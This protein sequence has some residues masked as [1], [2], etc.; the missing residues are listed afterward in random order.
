MKTESITT[1]QKSGFM[2]IMLISKLKYLGIIYVL[3]FY[4]SAY[5]QITVACAAN[6]QYAMEQIKTSYAKNGEDIKV[7]YGA[8][9]KFVSQIKNGAPFDVFV[10][11]DMSY[12]ESLYVWKY[13]VT[14]PQVYAYGKLVI[15]TTKNIDIAKG[16]AS[17]QNELVKTIAVPDPKAAPYGR[18]A[19]RALKNAGLYDAILPH[20]V[21]GESISQTAQYIVIGS[22][23]IGFNA[24][25]IVLSEQMKGKGKWVDVDSSLYT[26]IAQGA[27][28]CRYGQDNNPKLSQQ[29]VT[30]L[31]GKESR[32]IL[33]SYG[34]MLPKY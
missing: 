33:E 7:I 27:V 20:L 29:F 3:L 31:S 11:A 5:S 10:S 1:N 34:Y 18:E 2:V 21:Y 25:A 13:T 14:K 26:P 17:V 15:W 30:Y 8:S 32:Y 19:I 23:D 24:K 22:A 16:I 28:I 4:N 9:G 12:P 6:M